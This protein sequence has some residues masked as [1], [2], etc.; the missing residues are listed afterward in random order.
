MT[1]QE[2]TSALSLASLFALRMLGLFLVMPVFVLH[3]RTLPGGDD[4]TAVGL[5]MGIYGL[6]QGLLQIPFGMASDKLGR[7]RVIVAGLMLFVLG[8]VVAALAQTVLTLGL[9]RALQGAGA[10]S[11]AV[12]AL[13]ADST[14]DAVRTK[15]MAL[16]GASI[17]LTFALSLVIAPPLYASIGLSG[18]FWITAGLS[19]AAIWLVVRVVPDPPAQPPTIAVPF[20]QVLSDTQ[21]LRLNLGIFCLHAAQMAAF[22]VVPVLLAEQAQLPVPQHWKVYLLAVLGSF[23]FMMPLI[24]WGERRGKVKLVFVLA[25][26][27]ISVVLLSFPLLP[28]TSLGLGVGLFGFFVA[29]NVLEASLPSL[30][31]RFAPPAAKG[32][33]LGVYNTTQA[34]GLFV[35]GMLGGWVSK[36]YGGAAVFIVCGALCV[37]WLLAALGM[38]PVPKRG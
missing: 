8:S 2:R 27:M 33:A 13:L 19:T 18:L 28:M 32:A 21:L 31:S 25:I 3:A 7:K 14:R 12:T 29:F 10:I 16:I 1:A 37:I 4:A 9:G 5:A 20:S 15:A 36:Q 30:V 38:K 24:G 6:T 34:L 22:T 11:A 26:A 35:G 17:G 23:F